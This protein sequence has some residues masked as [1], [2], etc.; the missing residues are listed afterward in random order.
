M[1]KLKTLTKEAA[2]KAKKI[3]DKAKKEMEEK[4][5]EILDKGKDQIKNLEESK[6]KGNQ[7]KK[8]EE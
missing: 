7:T 5:N 4:A 3:A 1:E 6:D 2:D 8:L